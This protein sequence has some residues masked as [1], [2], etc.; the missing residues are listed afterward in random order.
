MFK[1]HRKLHLWLHSVL[2]CTIHNMYLCL[3]LFLYVLWYIYIFFFLLK[4][5]SF[6]FSFKRGCGLICGLL[7][8]MFGIFCTFLAKQ[9][10][11]KIC[12]RGVNS[13]YKERPYTVKQKIIF[14]CHCT[15]FVRSR[16]DNFHTS[17]SLEVW[18]SVSVARI[19]RQ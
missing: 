10:C 18:F 5:Q 17:F 19:L 4:V 15:Y 12:T 13:Q 8:H 2:Q 11:V 7:C 3:S 6:N 16:C 1:L 9:K 14:Y